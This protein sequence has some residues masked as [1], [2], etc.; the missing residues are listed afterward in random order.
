MTKMYALLPK[1]PDITEDQFHHHWSTVHHDHALKIERIRRYVQSHRIDGAVPGIKLINFDGV[2]ECWFDNLES[3]LGMGEDPSYTENALQDE[4]NFIDM[5]GIGFVMTENRV[6]VGRGLLEV[7]TPAV[8]AIVMVRR[9]PA[10]DVADFQNRWWSFAETLSDTL[11]KVIRTAAS[12]TDSR[13]YEAGRQ[14]DGTA[15]EFDGFAEIWWPD[16][17]SF[18]QSWGE[19]GERIIKMLNDVSD[20]ESTVAGLFEELRVI[21]PPESDQESAE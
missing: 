2:P 4:P 8:K 14:A 5:D 10:D 7:A 1:R 20:P 19:A 17:A 21:W 3:A 13:M 6:L 9:R 18:D 11:P 15:P 12:V 16:R